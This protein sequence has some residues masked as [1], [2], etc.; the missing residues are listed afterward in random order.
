M[1]S[2]QYIAKVRSQM[3]AQVKFSM[4]QC[5]SHRVLSLFKVF[6]L[7]LQNPRQTGGDIVTQQMKE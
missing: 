3:L 1:L 7:S 4:R 6:S 2:D 5:S